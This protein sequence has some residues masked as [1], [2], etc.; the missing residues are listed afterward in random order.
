MHLSFKPARA[1]TAF[2]WGLLVISLQ[3]NGWAQPA[4]A[5]ATATA[6]AAATAPASAKAPAAKPAASGTPGQPGP[7]WAALTPAQRQALAPLAATWDGLNAGQQRKWLEISRNYPGLAPADQAK[8]HGRMSEWVGL[9]ARERTAARL[10][11]AATT[12]IAKELSPEEKKAKWEAYQSLSPDERKKLAEQGSRPPVGAAP[13]TRPVAP[14]KL[15]TLPGTSG[16]VNSTPARPPRSP[17]EP[18]SD[19]AK[20][21]PGAA[22]AAPAAPAERVER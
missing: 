13:A 19:L 10:N 16:S 11:F 1:A 4:A 12:E 21:T 15:A 8:M 14:Q 20:P 3:G 5:P 7:A 18:K 17:A 2:I 9:S 22:E 6:P